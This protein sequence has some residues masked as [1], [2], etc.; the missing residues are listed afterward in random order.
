MHK[1]NC[2]WPF[3]VFFNINN[4]LGLVRVQR[5]ILNSEKNVIVALKRDNLHC[6]IYYANFTPWNIKLFPPFF[7][8]FFPIYVQLQLMRISRKHAVALTP[9][10][11]DSGPVNQWQAGQVPLKSFATG[12]LLLA[13][14]RSLSLM[15]LGVSECTGNQ[16]YA[17]LVS[18]RIKIEDNSS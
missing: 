17:S 4:W 14:S 13:L 9:S 16:L 2:R 5:S 3:G 11:L 12:S 15:I 7:V 6:I 1:T 18:F 10:V 8:L